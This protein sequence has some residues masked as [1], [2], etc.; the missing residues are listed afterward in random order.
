MKSKELGKGNKFLIRY[1]LVLFI[2]QCITNSVG[3][4]GNFLAL[5]EIGTPATN[6]IVSTCILVFIL[7]VLIGT[8]Y[9][10]IRTFQWTWSKKARENRLLRMV[11]LKTLWLALA[12]LTLLIFL[13][14]ISVG[15]FTLPSS[16]G[17][18]L[19]RYLV[20]VFLSLVEIICLT[21]FLE[22]YLFR[23]GFMK[24][25]WKGMQGLINPA[26]S[27]VSFPTV[28]TRTVSRQSVGS[29]GGVASISPVN[30]SVVASTQQISEVQDSHSLSSSES[31]SRTS[32]SQSNESV[33]SSTGS[34]SQKEQEGTV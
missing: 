14:S 26:T 21:L 11:G 22:N 29:S 31:E 28:K 10:I 18:S 23:H 33:G 13:I 30:S 8:T 6:Y 25:Y 1:R 32:K 27:P 7:V 2:T 19:V 34:E 4:I 24:S 9:H 3:V 20:S 5:F 12:N 15:L 17:V 16:R